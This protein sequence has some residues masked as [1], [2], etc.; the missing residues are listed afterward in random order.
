[1]N[2]S[3]YLKKKHRI[4]TY[5]VSNTYNLLYVPI[6]KNAS[7]YVTH[8]FKDVLKWQLGCDEAIRQLDHNY[9]KLWSCIKHQRKIVI[10]Q[11]P[12]ARWIKGISQF[13]IQVLPNLDP[14]N[15]ELLKLL[16]THMD[17]DDHTTPQVNFIHNLDTDDIDFFKL[18]ENLDLNLNTYLASKIPNEYVVIPDNLYKNETKEYS[19]KYSLQNKLKSIIDNDESIKQKIINYYMDDYKLLNTIKFYGT[20]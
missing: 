4:G 1:M 17:F 2:I 19:C 6:P 15:D 13:A 10:L 9:F 5:Y 11:D 7:Q 16:Y 18:D 12:L 3:G 8:Y 14:N 20:N